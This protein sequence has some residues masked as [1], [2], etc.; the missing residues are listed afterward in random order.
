VN[1]V[2]AAALADRLVDG[3]VAVIGAEDPGPEP[4]A[5]LLGMAIAGL[6]QH[7]VSELTIAEMVTGSLLAQRRDLR[8]VS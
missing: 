7:G 4:Y 5:A 3:V 2:D 8:A 1:R 6:R